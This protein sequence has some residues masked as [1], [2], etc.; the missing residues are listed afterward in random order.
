MGH[1]EYNTSTTQLQF[2]RANKKAKNPMGE[3]APSNKPKNKIIK[4]PHTHISK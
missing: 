1:G 2:N 4:N 3:S